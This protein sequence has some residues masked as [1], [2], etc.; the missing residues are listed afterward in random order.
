MMIIFSEDA[1]F[2]YTSDLQGPL[3]LKSLIETIMF[4]FKV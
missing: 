3:W 1:S 2:T 4:K